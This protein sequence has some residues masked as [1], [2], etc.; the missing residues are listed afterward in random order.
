MQVQIQEPILTT[1]GASKADFEAVYALLAKVGVPINLVT[2]YD[3]IGDNYAWVVKLPVQVMHL[4][5]TLLQDLNSLLHKQ[6]DLR[7]LFRWTSWVCRAL[8]SPH[9]RRS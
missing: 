4:F 1:A 8:R 2:A 5:T 7:R 9:R 6:E 3:D